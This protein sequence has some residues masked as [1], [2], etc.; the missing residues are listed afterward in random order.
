MNAKARV[1]LEWLRDRSVLKNNSDL[2]NWLII[3]SSDGLS[4]L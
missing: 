4:N 1:F 2:R 3:M